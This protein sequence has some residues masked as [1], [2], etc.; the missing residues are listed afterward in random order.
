MVGDKI[1]VKVF[2]MKDVMRF[3]KKG[4]LSPLFIRPFEVL[5]RI[6]EVA[7]ELALPPSLSGVHSVFY[8]SMLR[9]YIGDLS[10]VLDFSMVKLDGDL[11]YDLEPVAILERQ[12]R[13]LRS[14][15]I[16]LVKVQWRDQPEEEATWETERVVRSKYPHLFEASSMFLDS[17]KD[18]RLFKRGKK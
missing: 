17:F 1:L 8:V 3:G 16:A 2:P 10:H 5:Q 9:K 15:D 7:Y 11:T 18:E 12:V 6:G 14:K 13:K 4:K